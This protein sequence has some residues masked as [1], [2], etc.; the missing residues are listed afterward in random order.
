M[1]D[2]GRSIGETNQLFPARNRKSG[3][4]CLGDRDHTDALRWLYDFDLT[5][6]SRPGPELRSGAGIVVAN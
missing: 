3:H 1:T 2:R 5:A 4:D 6:C